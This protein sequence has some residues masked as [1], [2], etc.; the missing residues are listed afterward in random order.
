MTLRF[1][2]ERIDPPAALLDHLGPA[3]FAW[4]PEHGVR[5]VTSGVAATAPAPAVERTL[6]A[7]DHRAPAGAPPAAGPLAVGALGFDG[8]RPLT[9]PASVLALDAD[10]RA[11]RTTVAGAPVPGSAARRAHPTRFVLTTVQSRL[12]WARQVG[13]ALDLVARGALD[14]VVL[15]REIVVEG[16]VAFDVREVARRLA[17]DQPGCVVYVDGGFVG[18]TPELLVRVDGGLVQSRPMAGTVARGR[19]VEADDAAVAALATSEKQ[20]WEHR[21]VIDRVTEVLGARC[22]QV[23]VRGPE[24]ER[25]ATVT[26]L[27]TDVWAK[28]GEDVSALD[29]A[30]ALHP[31][32]A[33][34]G[35]PTAA[36]LDAIRRIEGFDRGCYA[37]PVGWVAA[38]GDGEFAVALRGAQVSGA[39]ARVLAGAGI[40]RGSEPE[41]EWAETEAKFEPVLRALARP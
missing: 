34:G 5:L 35:T 33:V 9:I 19:T 18:A 16:D 2:T 10:G 11:W 1:D 6:A 8:R 32:P 23:E 40:V 22:E 29:L 14:K 31:T 26:H 24:P 20:A 36:A 7:A 21:L 28:A 41:A 3:G 4:L 15:A 39:A 12:V 38:G 13:E 37:G 30:L 25:F 27:V 17:D